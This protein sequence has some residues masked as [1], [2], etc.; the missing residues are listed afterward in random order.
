MTD[1]GHHLISQSSELS[2][3]SEV[4][5]DLP[6]DHGLRGFHGWAPEG[7]RLMMP[8]RLVDIL[9]IIEFRDLVRFLSE[10]G[11][12][13]PRRL[14]IRPQTERRA[15][16]C[17]VR[18]EMLSRGAMLRA[19]TLRAVQESPTPYGLADHQAALPE[20]RCLRE[21]NTLSG[22]RLEVSCSFPLRDTRGVDCP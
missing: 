7:D 5:T 10:L 22:L 14:T 21:K 15:S 11:K 6:F 19:P 20:Q 13:A 4:K 1:F 12:P 2:V 9:T 16:L 3:Q 18:T 8:T 17:T